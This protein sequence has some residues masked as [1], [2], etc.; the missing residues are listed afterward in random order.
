ME[1]LE[2]L[3][4][5]LEEMED[6][7]KESDLQEAIQAL[8]ASYNHSSKIRKDMKLN[9]HQNGLWNYSLTGILGLIVSAIMTTAYMAKLILRNHKSLIDNDIES[10]KDHKSNIE[11]TRRGRKHQ[12]IH[13]DIK[14][15]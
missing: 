14:I 12:S 13:L 3:T 9:T 7:N 6:N 4:E 5:K 8:E 15:L 11:D 2:R 10:L 1:D